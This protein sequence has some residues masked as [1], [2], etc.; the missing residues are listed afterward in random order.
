MKN[1]N[2]LRGEKNLRFGDVRVLADL[3]GNNGTKLGDSD[4]LSC[5][6]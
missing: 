3:K 5:K 6:L 1:L 2:T 4:N